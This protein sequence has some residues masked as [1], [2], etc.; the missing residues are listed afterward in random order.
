M[1]PHTRNTWGIHVDGQTKSRTV[2]AL[3]VA[4][5]SVPTC[6]PDSAVCVCACVCDGLGVGDGAVRLHVVDVVELVLLVVELLPPQR[7]TPAQAKGWKERRSNPVGCFFLDFTRSPSHPFARSPVRPRVRP[8]R[9]TCRRVGEIELTSI[10]VKWNGSGRVRAAR[11]RPERAPRQVV[12]LVPRQC[13]AKG[14]K[15]N[16]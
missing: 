5:C 1:F 15:N 12:D 9:C 16:K 13:K 6:A 7:E 8:K 4:H 10:W 3:P 2:Y 14:V 11:V